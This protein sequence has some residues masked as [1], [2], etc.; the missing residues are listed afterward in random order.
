MS[1]EGVVSRFFH[2]K[3]NLTLGADGQALM[4]VFLMQL[5]VYQIPMGAE[6]K[7]SVR[8]VARI[9]DMNLLEND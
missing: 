3:A 7:S 5:N 4:R 6:L 9:W 1:V 8:N 2:P